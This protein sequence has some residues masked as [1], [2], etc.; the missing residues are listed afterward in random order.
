MNT[1]GSGSATGTNKQSHAANWEGLL[2]IV[3]ALLILVGLCV[4]VTQW[5]PL[6]AA[7][8]AE[9]PK[10]APSPAAANA[11]FEYL[12]DQYVNQATQVEEPIPTF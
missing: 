12:P 1:C 9:A 8:V 5:A 2:L 7:A 6:R 4:G 11:P 10:P 3:A